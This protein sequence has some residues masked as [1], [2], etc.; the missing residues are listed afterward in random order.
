MSY[1]LEI[2]DKNTRKVKTLSTP[3]LIRS[4]TVPVEYVNGEY[5][6]IEQTEAEINITYNYVMYF[7][8]ATQGDERF[9]HPSVINPGAIEYGIRGLSGRTACESLPMIADMIEK[10]TRKYRDED[11]NWLKSERTKIQYFTEDGKEVNFWEAMSHGIKT[12]KKETN[13]WVSEGDTVNYWECTAAN[14]IKSLKNMLVMATD[15]VND[16]DAVW[17]VQ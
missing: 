10:L 4:G 1:D 14:A 15:F 2:V 11:G 12:T 17:S 9:A 13:Y 6:Q 3:R 7:E 5:N 8:E 16:P